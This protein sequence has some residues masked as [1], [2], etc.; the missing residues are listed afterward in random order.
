MDLNKIID[1]LPTIKVELEFDGNEGTY[2]HEGKEIEGDD[3][4]I[5]FDLEVYQKIQIDKATHWFPVQYAKIH[6]SVNI[7]AVELWLDGSG[8]TAAA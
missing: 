4:L 1:Q 3:F 6:Q 7:E 2:D 8:R 5:R